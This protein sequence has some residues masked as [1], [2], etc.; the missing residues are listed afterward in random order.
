MLVG[1]K[2]NTSGAKLPP[3]GK[4]MSHPSANVPEGGIGG[5]E[6]LPTPPHL[7]FAR[8]KAHDF[9]VRAVQLSS[10]RFHFVFILWQAHVKKVNV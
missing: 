3:L 2:K 1:G 9:A 4:P 7:N 8:G 6:H 5:G 10:H